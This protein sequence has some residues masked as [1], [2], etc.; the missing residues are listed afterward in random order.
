MMP[1]TA[2]YAVSVL[3]CT[4]G[5]IAAASAAPGGDVE[6]KDIWSRAT[7]P[8]IEVGVAYLVIDNH[9]KPDRLLGASSPIA[10]RTELHISEMKDGLMTMRRLDAVEIKTG[11]PTA[12]APGGRHI[13]L[14][15]L[16]Q[17]L[18]DGDRFP[19]T[20]TFK[21]AGPVQVTVPVFGI[22]KRPYQRH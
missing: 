18:K 13:M 19:L 1:R 12:F 20:L 21:N 10:K 15:G 22:G 9:G 11:A 3:V 17:P 5:L 8:G 4:I 7:P 14:I 2:K 6:I 16:K